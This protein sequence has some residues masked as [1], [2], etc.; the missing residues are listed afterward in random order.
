MNQQGTIGVV[1]PVATIVE[2]I[3][4]AIIIISTEARRANG[5]T[6]SLEGEYDRYVECIKLIF[7]NW[8]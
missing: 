1:G 8:V 2:M 5:R 4:F 6:D 7:D 3:S